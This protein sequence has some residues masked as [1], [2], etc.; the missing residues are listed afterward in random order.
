MHRSLWKLLP[1]ADAEWPD[2]DACLPKIEAVLGAPT[3][4]DERIVVFDLAHRAL[5]H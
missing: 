4:R 3:Y 1:A 5:G 2:V